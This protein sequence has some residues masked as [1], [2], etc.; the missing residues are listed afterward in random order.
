MIEENEEEIEVEAGDAKSFYFN[1][2]GRGLQEVSHEKG[3]CGRERIQENRGALQRGNRT[4][5]LGNYE[6]A[7][8]AG[9]KGPSERVLRQSW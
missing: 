8:G 5:R 6:Q 4:N 2:G 9:A 1:K 3:V 7:Y